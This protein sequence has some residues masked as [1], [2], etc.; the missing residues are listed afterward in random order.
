MISIKTLPDSNIVEFVVDGEISKEEFDRV[1]AHMEGEIQTH[2]SIRLLE[3]LRSIGKF[4]ISRLWDDLK[5]SFEH[6]KDIE[7][8]AV[9]GQSRWLESWTKVGDAFTTCP[10]RYFSIDDIDDA[11]A[12]LALDSSATA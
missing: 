9:V 3:E 7:R 4:P 2:G 11:R 6:L 8:C 12:W 10:V 5:F 1:L